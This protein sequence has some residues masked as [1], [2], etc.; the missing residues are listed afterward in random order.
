MNAITA[1]YKEITAKAEMQIEGLVKVMPSGYIQIWQIMLT[2]VGEV[3][4][5]INLKPAIGW[6]PGL[7]QSKS[8]FVLDLNQT[9][10]FLLL[11]KIGELALLLNTEVPIGQTATIMMTTI[12]TG[13]PDQVLQAAVEMNGN[14][15]AVHAADT[16]RIQPK[17]QEIVAPDEEG[18][19]STPTLILAKSP[20]LATRSNMV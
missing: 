7:A 2:N 4:L 10:L 14:F 12:A 19:I 17:N 15:S 6:S 18:F 9:K 1:V 13:E 16:V 11:M 8:R 3:P 20:F 5:K